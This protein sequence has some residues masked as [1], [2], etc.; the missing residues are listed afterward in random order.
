MAA[1]KKNFKTTDN[2]AMNFITLT[3]TPQLP[4][5]AREEGKTSSSMAGAG[6]APQSP[7]EASGAIRV[8]THALE[9]KRSKRFSL[10]VPPS[11][12]DDLSTATG[13]E[14]T[15]LNNLCIEILQAYVE[16]NRGRI[17]R[18]RDLTNQLREE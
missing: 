11:L 14:R 17:D 3:Q 12:F 13:C 7:P 10:A 15:N 8:L 9:E 16:E 4:S 2:P 5:S 6:N 18:F 1:Y